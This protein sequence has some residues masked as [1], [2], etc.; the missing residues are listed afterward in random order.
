MSLKQ[1]DKL[2]GIEARLEP[3]QNKQPGVFLHQ[4]FHP[5]PLLRAETSEPDVSH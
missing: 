1:S 4:C 3:G 2:F 5:N